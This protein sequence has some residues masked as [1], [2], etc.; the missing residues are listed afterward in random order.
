MGN[1]V[2]LLPFCFDN[3]TTALD[4]LIGAAANG[5]ASTM[6]FGRIS[7]DTNGMTPADQ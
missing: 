3:I 5:A 1:P 2:L 7:S 6:S 4:C